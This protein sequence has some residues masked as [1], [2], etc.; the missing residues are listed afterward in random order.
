MA[1]GL[2]RFQQRGDLHFVTF[3]CY[4]RQDRLALPETRDLF[5][6][7][8]ERMRSKYEFEVVAYVV[9]P[10]H[11][12]LLLSEPLQGS[13][14][15]GVQAIKLSVARRA[16]PQPFWQARYY[17]FNVFSEGKRVEKLDYIH[18]NPV[19][20]GLVETMEQWPWSSYQS[21]ATGTSG[22]VHLAME[23]TMHWKPTAD[24]HD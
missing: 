2:K 7:A 15:L 18:F 13:L 17:D 8:L 14:A 16:S 6:D 23:W 5:V 22:L 20:R 19:K 1:E 3:C 11:V 10:E 9:M 21:Y 24:L 4:H 12:H